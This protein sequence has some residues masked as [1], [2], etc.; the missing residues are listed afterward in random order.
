MTQTLKFAEAAALQDLGTYVK[1]A[2]KIEQQGIRLQAVG[3]VVA[4]WVPVMT[5]SSLVGRLPAVLGLRTM[6][7]GEASSADVTVELDSITERLARLEGSDVE[8]SLP[9]SQ[10]NAPWAAVT[11]PRSGWEPQGTVTDALLR[12]TA[13]EGI[14]RIADAVPDS[15]GAAV[16]EQLR[17]RV[18]GDS[19]TQTPQIPAGAAFGAYS[20]GFLGSGDDATQVHTLGRWTRLSSKG[21][22][23]L[24]R[25]S[26][27]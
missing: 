11:P 3:P 7:L 20:L 23:V 13:E 5:P 16:V 17:E 4:A 1:R 18:W 2:K 26:G 25:T 12:E 8:L 10:V 14:S 24:A 21:G 27:M 15:A 9:P 19:V 22:F 6:K